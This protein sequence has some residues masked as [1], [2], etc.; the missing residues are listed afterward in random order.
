MDNHKQVAY[1]DSSFVVDSIG[2]LLVNTFVG[3]YHKM[4]AVEYSLD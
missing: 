1:S 4:R 3:S 2:F